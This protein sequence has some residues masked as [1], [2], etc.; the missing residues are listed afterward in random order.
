MKSTSAITLLLSALVTAAIAQD[1]PRYSHTGPTVITNV[2]VIDGLGG[3]PRESQD[4]VLTDG[5]ITYIGPA[6]THDASQ[7]TLVI[8][9]R[10][11]TAM[12]GLIDMHVH[13][14]G[15]WANG[16]ISGDRYKP[17][18]DDESVQQSLNAH[19]YAGV[20]TVL[21]CGSDHDYVLKWRTRIKRWLGIR[22]PLLHDRRTMGPGAEWLGGR[23][24]DRGRNVWTFDQ[25]DRYRRTPGTNGQVQ[26]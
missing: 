7:D 9:G 2:R 17:R 26:E 11:M 21:D 4:I 3:G 1:Q 20:T 25:G 15:G 8:D 6:G 24:Y 22:A 14:Q 10:G 13:L 18:Y 16:T 19:L 5:K 23:Q 12:P